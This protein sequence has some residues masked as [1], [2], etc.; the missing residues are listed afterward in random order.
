LRS[1]GASHPPVHAINRGIFIEGVGCVLAGI[2]GT[3]TGTTS[4]SQNIG[5]IGI[6]KVGSRRVIQVSGLIMVIFAL[7]GKIGAVFV[8]IPEPGGLRLH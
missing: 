3:G 2:F 6:S 5:A 8:S 1:A 7:I 4:L